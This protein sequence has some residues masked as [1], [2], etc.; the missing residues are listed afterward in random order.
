M[1]YMHP[2]EFDFKAINCRTNHPP[3]KH[4]PALAAFVFNRKW[5]LFRRSIYGKLKDLLE[6]YDFITCHQKA[7][8]VKRTHS[9]GI[10]ECSK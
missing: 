5:N 4:Y 7:E 6:N 1:L 2:Y 8:Y 9:P 3:D 10:L